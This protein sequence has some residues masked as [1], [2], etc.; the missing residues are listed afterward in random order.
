MFAGL[1]KTTL[2]DY[3][4]HTACVLFTSG[5]NFRCPY[6][7]NPELVRRGTAP[8]LHEADVFAFLESRRGFLDAVVIS[9]GEPTL[10]P[11]LAALCARI[12][13][14]GYRLKLDTN[15]SRPEVLRR[16][17]A[18]GLVDYLAMDVKTDGR[19]YGRLTSEADAAAGTAA[20]VEAVLSSGIAHEFRTTCVAPLVDADAVGD[21]IARIRGARL[22]VLQRFV[23]RRVLDQRF[24]E[25]GDRRVAESDL[26]RWRALAENRGIRC[27]IR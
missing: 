22:Y 24:F 3:P 9:G 10:Q 13:G 15:G 17:I 23:G 16:L 11:G 6:C 18:G 4:G 26:D 14:M 8:V 2:I 1:Q 12:K 27:I 25:A 21:I 19:R 5:C 20:G 7:H